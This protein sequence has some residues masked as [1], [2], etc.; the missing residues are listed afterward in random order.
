VPQTPPSLAQA[1]EEFLAMVEGIRPELHR[2]CARLMGSVIEGEDIVQDALAKALYGLSLQ[3]EIPL[4]RPWLFRIAHNQAM[5][6]LKS[7]ARK[8]TEVREDL[9]DVAGYEDRP[10]PAIVRAALGRFLELPVVQRSA[11]ILKDVLGH[12]L[13]ETAETMGTT[14]L[15]VKAALVRGRAR[16]GEPEE[17]R[18]SAKDA[19]TRAALDRY[20]ALFNARDWDGVR[21]LVSDDCRLDLVSK[22]QRRGKAV[23]MYFS[24]Y[25]KEDVSLRVVRLEGEL[26]LAAYVGRAARP[27]YFI[28]LEWSAGR[29][30][31]IRDFRYVAYVASEAEVEEPGGAHDDVGRITP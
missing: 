2:Y 1:R 16:L 18:R 9:E 12:S 5:D 15:A 22:S 26:V 28:L 10:D 29:V 30:A 11:V 31:S 6:F 27:A 17:E 23:G 13:E 8:Y 3:P 14:V 20:A 7:H 4:L 24:R 21:A 19:G 25:E